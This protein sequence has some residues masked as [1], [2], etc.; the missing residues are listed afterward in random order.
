M[1]IANQSAAGDTCPDVFI[2]D[3]A[4]ADL[5]GSTYNSDLDVVA[6]AYDDSS[7]CFIPD[8]FLR[9]RRTALRLDNG[10][11]VRA[12]DTVREYSMVGSTCTSPDP[13]ICP[14]WCQY[15]P[16]L[17][18]GFTA[19]QIVSLNATRLRYTFE[20]GPN[21]PPVRVILHASNL[22]AGPD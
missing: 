1:I 7:V 8:L 16:D 14:G 10:N 5:L 9:V 18:A 12:L 17:F 3:V 19:A 6:R 2:V 15:A 4:N 21:V 11:L 20:V 22:C 13:R